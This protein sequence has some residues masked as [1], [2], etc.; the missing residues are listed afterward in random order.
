MHKHTLFCNTFTAFDNFV[1]IGILSTT[2]S[3][4]SIIKLEIILHGYF[5]CCLSFH[6]TSSEGFPTGFL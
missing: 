2:D 4:C 3:C 5:L 6:A 1:Q